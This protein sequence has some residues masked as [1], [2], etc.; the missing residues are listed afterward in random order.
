PR[1]RFREGVRRSPASRVTP[2]LSAIVV[3]HR[4]GEHAV[5][6]V[7]SLRSAM[8]TDGLRGE[9]LLVDC[10]SGPEEVGRLTEAP[11]HARLLLAENRGYSGGL[12]AGLARARSGRLLLSNADVVFRPGCLRPLL[13]AAEEGRVGAAAPILFWD[14]EDR[15]RL[16]P[17]YPVRFW[18]DA[19]QLLG[20]RLP[21][22]KRRFAA[23]ARTSARLW[24]DGGD[25]AQLT[26]AV[27]AA[28]KDVFDR[29]GRFDERFPFEF[30]ETEWEDRIRKAGLRLRVV[31]ASR[32]RHLWARSAAAREE[33]SARRGESRRLY[34]QTRYG[35]VGRAVLEAMASR[36]GAADGAPASEPDVPA[37]AGAS[38]AI[39]PNASL[40][41]FAAASLDRDF[42]LP[43]DLREALAPGPLFLTT[44]RDSDGFPLETRVWVKR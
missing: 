8:E 20:R 23:F 21:G 19:S 29:V 16:P 37:R 35:P 11:A 38:L 13:D 26:G 34:R 7:K 4:S 2:D 5:R 28:R 18:T 40:L 30:E 24:S 44:F 15:I 32:A 1:A 9:I 10:G 3:N 22:W 41:P 43:S 6:C 36:P 42:R 25:A 33:T 39:T 14:A 27:L 12:N 17:G 31:T